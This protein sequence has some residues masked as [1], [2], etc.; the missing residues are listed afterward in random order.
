M[1]T[2][3]CPPYY[4]TDEIWWARLDAPPCSLNIP[5][6]LTVAV[7]LCVSRFLIAFI[8]L[9]D[10]RSRQIY[11]TKKYNSVDNAKRLPVQPI[12]SMYTAITQTLFF[13]LASTD[14]IS[15]RDGTSYVMLAWWGIGFLSVEFLMFR[16]IVTLG[17]KIIP[18]GKRYRSETAGEVSGSGSNNNH[19]LSHSNSNSNRKNTSSSRR[20]FGK[21]EDL[22]ELTLPLRLLSGIFWGGV[23]IVFI[24]WNS[25]PILVLGNVSL[26]DRAKVAQGGWGGGLISQL[27]ACVGLLFQMYRCICAVE[28]MIDALPEGQTGVEERQAIQRMW[29][30]IYTFIA[31]FIV[32]LSVVG[33]GAIDGNYPWYLIL[34][35]AFL[36]IFTTGSI[37]AANWCTA[38]SNRKKKGASHRFRSGGGGGGRNN[39]NNNNNR[40]R[41]DTLTNTG[42]GDGVGD[43][44]SGDN[45]NSRR[46]HAVSTTMVVSSGGSMSGGA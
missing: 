24:T 21:I 34:V 45:S 42:V 32:L 18:L 27:A 46:V 38:L 2:T 11:L 41:I 13:V 29:Y 44:N 28:N 15:V 5:A 4:A 33:V 9:R 39:N 23:V 30:S 35:I 1:N 20:N 14:S 8:H 37:L 12:A 19:H 7:W 3:N 16:R 17:H 31:A 6:W 40:D 43:G 10:W 36:D 26:L 22:S 25:M